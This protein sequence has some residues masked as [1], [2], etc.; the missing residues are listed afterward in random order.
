MHTC[1]LRATEDTKDEEGRQGWVVDRRLRTTPQHVA[2]DEAV[3]VWPAI[4]GI[5]AWGGLDGVTLGP[6]WTH[7]RR[8]DGVKLAGRKKVQ[9]I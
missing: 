9:Q 5:E 2:V 4:F 6:K 3:T 1:L 8:F 7:N